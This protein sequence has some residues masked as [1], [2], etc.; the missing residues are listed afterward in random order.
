MPVSLTDTTTSLPCRSAVSQ[1]RPPRLG[2]LGGVVEQV[3]EHLGQPGQVGV[4]DDRAAGGSV[5][6]SSWP[7]CSMSG[8]LVSTALLHHRR[9]FDPLLA[10]FQ[11]AAG[12]AAH[13]QQVVH[14]PH[15]LPKLPLHH[16]AGLLSGVPVG[17][18]PDDLQGVADRG[19]RVA[20]FVGQRRQELV[21]AAVG[22][23]QLGGDLTQFVLQPLP[24]G[25]VP[26]DLGRPDDP[27]LFVPDGRDG[28][29]NGDGRRPSA[30]AP[31]RSVRPAP[32]I[33]CGRR[34][35]PLRRGGRRGMSRVMGRPTASSA[36]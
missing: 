29:R 9:Q 21:L 1:M 6:V 12:D 26:G 16:G 30:A 36:V 32:R 5:T 11:L 24:L 22:L 17:R 23:R 19:Q 8:R 7:I 3:G 25:D 35:A 10:E 4:H 33:G 31:C 28:Q 14:Q 34:S 15:H 2:V 13:V 20:E 27:P 18:Q